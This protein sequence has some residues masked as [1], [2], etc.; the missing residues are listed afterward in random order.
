MPDLTYIP[1]RR[2]R[3]EPMTAL[4]AVEWLKTHR[5]VWYQ[6]PMDHRVSR[7]TC[8]SK[9]KLWKRDLTRF[10]VSVEL[11]GGYPRPEV[12]TL[13][14]KH[15][16]RLKMPFE[17]WHHGISATV[18]HVDYVG[19]PH[20][21]VLSQSNGFHLTMGSLS[22]AVNF[23]RRQCMK[24]TVQKWRNGVRRERVLVPAVDPISGERTFPQ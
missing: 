13:D 5:Y 23:A 9:L 14:N 21:I 6:A 11:P 17:L 1:D 22:H 20:T 12:F 8:T 4:E 7:L 3:P 2:F 19:S 16:D 24:L 18:A 15:L 10:Q